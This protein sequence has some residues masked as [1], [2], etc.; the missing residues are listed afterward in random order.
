[1]GVDFVG[2]A[3]TYTVSGKVIDG[4]GFPLG[5]LDIFASSGISAT[6]DSAGFYTLYGLVA[7]T[8]I[9]SPTSEGYTFYPVS[10]TVSV[11]PNVEGVNF[12]AEFLY[13]YISVVLGRE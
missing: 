13:F 4:D 10:R 6:T 1:M 9:I 5:G 11:P 8:H 2:N 3:L 12:I 7:G